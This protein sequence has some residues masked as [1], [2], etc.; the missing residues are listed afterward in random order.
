MKSL[1]SLLGFVW[2]ALALAATGF[3]DVL[4]CFGGFEAMANT[5]SGA[6][7]HLGVQHHNDPPSHCREGPEESDD[8]ARMDCAISAEGWC[9]LLRVIMF[10]ACPWPP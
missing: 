7:E 5:L 4:R 6:F 3:I 1:R 2:T 10:V 9:L 8:R